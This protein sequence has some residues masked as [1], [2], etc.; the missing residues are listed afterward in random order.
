M[1]RLCS[2]AVD[3]AARNAPPLHMD[4]EN[5]HGGRIA[6]ALPVPFASLLA[7]PRY[8][9]YEQK[10]TFELPGMSLARTVLRTEALS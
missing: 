5:K 9:N 6:A 2:Q 1:L 8:G 3:A 7:F 4:L 10:F